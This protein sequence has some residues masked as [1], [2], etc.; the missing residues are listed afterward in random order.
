MR[1]YCKCGNVIS[2]TQCPNDVELRVYTDKEFDDIINMEIND[3]LDI[4]RPKQDVLICPECKRIYVYNHGYGPPIAV[5]K[6]EEWS[7]ESYFDITEEG[8]VSKK[9]N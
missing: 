5:Y 6:L 3:P 7:G 2:T 9:E 4:P 8:S 1:V